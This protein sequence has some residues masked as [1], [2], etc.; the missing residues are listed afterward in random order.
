MTLQ[1]PDFN[2]ARVLVVGDLMLDQY[3]HGNSKRISPEAPV[4]VVHVRRDELRPGGAS[5]VAVN[6]RAL[7]GQVNLLGLTGADANARRLQQLLEDQGI[8]CH[9]QQ[10]PELDTCVK[11]RIIAQHQQM[12]RLDF[13]DEFREVA[14]DTLLAHY[15]KHLAQADLVVLSD[16]NKGTLSDV[17]EL[18]RLAREQNKPVIVDPKGNDFSKY[19]GATLLTPNRSEFEAVTGAFSDNTALEANGLQLCQELSLDALLVTRGEEGMTLLCQN[20]TTVH[21]PTHARE[22]FD[23]TG[24][25]DTVVATLAAA[26]AVGTDKQQAMQLANIAAGL[27]VRKLGTASVSPQEMQQAIQTQYR[28]EQDIVDEV[29]LEQL[30]KQAQQQGERVIMTNGCFDILHAGHVS[31]LQQARELGDRLVVAVNSDASVSALKGPERPV[32][33]LQSRMIVLAAL[34]CVDWVVPFTEDTP[35]RLYCRVLPDVIVKGGDYQEHEVAGGDCVKAAGGSVQ[36]LPFLSGHSTSHVIRKIRNPATD[37][38]VP[39]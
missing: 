10:C 19:H 22:V 6:I 12:I 5:N 36:I 2:Q 34:G 9:F 21:L 32:N 39:R 37:T 16:Y 17:S 13:E 38:S 30:I 11:L 23:V 26:M 24:A 28:A 1:L 4:P 29:Q 25:G 27:V 20:G 14:K 33:D 35:E 3:W 31:Y 15:R 18:I 7:G 8:Q